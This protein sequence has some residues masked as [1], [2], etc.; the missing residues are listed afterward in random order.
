MIEKILKLTIKNEKIMNIFYYGIFGILTTII[1]LAT[2][3]FL[4]IAGVQYAINAAISWVL[5]VFVAYITN[6]KIVFKSTA[7]GKNKLI[8]E[9]IRF[10]A[11]RVATLLINLF[12]LFIL[13]SCL[14]FDE[15]YSQ[16]FMNII[17]I[18]TNYFFSKITIISDKR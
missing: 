8:E 12:G 18:I 1:N 5:A 17:V 6:R 13:V 11:G 10:Y 7:K 9:A 4:K 14:K 16:I 15:W 2:F 3:Y